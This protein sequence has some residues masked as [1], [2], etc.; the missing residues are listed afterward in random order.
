[1]GL[2]YQLDIWERQMDLPI[3]FNAEDILS[4]K[5]V[6]YEFTKNYYDDEDGDRD[7]TNDRFGWQTLLDNG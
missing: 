7:P 6:A 5:I 1:M 2:P 3:D 4:E